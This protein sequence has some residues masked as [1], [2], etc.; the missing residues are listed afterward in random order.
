MWK[1]REKRPLPGSLGEQAEGRG[2]RNDFDEVRE[3]RKGLYIDDEQGGALSRYEIRY[4][5]KL[6]NSDGELAVLV[7][8]SCVSGMR[9]S[10]T[11]RPPTV[12]D[13]SR[14]LR[15]D[16]SLFKMSRHLRRDRASPPG[17]N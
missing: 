3:Q 9:E 2:A 13:S 8:S 1:D 14:N 6:L 10:E 16:F 4:G 5:P 17:N 15:I 11:P 12:I 7:R